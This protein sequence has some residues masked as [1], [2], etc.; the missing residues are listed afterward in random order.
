MKKAKKIFLITAFLLKCS[1]SMF[2]EENID[3]AFND[4]FQIEDK[5][6]ERK[7]NVHRLP[8]KTGQSSW[9]T[10]KGKPENFYSREKAFDGDPSTA[11]VEG[12]KGDG[13]GEYIYCYIDSSDFWYLKFQTDESQVMNFNV[14]IVNGYAKNENLFYKN[15]RAKKIRITIYDM[16]VLHYLPDGTELDDPTYHGPVFRQINKIGHPAEIVS[17]DFE[18]EDTMEMQT[19]NLQGRP[20][21]IN[22]YGTSYGL[23]ECF[24][25]I[26]ILDVYKGSAYDDTCISEIKIDSWRSKNH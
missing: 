13:L 15:N 20:Q 23:L 24:A 9:L 25:K 11:W 17:E 26:E 4:F 2:S 22:K 18:L 10:E 1:Y 5:T 14:S 7:T 19:F 3:K 16:E 6:S 21:W 8:W 12:K